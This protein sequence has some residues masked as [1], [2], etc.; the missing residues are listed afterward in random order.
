MVVHDSQKR[1][2]RQAVPKEALR[3]LVDA[4]RT[5]DFGSPRDA[6][7]AFAAVT[8]EICGAEA[9]VVRLAEPDGAGLTAHAVHATSPALAAELAGSRV[10]ADEASAS[11]RLEFAFTAPI[12]LDGEV[13]GSLDVLRDSSPFS[14]GEQLLAQLAAGELGLVLRALRPRP[15]DTES[16][17]ERALVLAGEALAAGSDAEHA[18]E[19]VARLAADAAGA[20]AVVL[21]R[22]DDGKPKLAASFGDSPAAESAALSAARI[23]LDSRN[24]FIKDRIGGAAVVSVRLGEPAVGVLQ[25]V[26][27]QDPDESVLSGLMTFALRA[28]QTLRAG[29]SSREAVR[30]L[31]RTRAL[32]AVVAQATAHLSLQHALAT[33]IE[34]VTVLVGADR[35]AVYLREGKRLQAAASRNLAGPHSAVAER[36]LELA[37]GPYRGR[38]MVIVSELGR[39][40]AFAEV[41]DAASEAG[42]RAA[43]ALPLVVRGEAIGLLAAYPTEG[44]HVS[45]ED[46]ALLAA[47]AAQLA[48]A[49]QNARLHEQTKTLA[50]DLDSSLD[51][52]REAA[53]RVR[54]LYEVSES[55]AQSLSL[56]ATLDALARSA[57]ELLGVDAAV[58]RMPDVRREMLEERAVHVGDPRLGEAAIPA[59]THPQTLD[60]VPI[61]RLFRTRRPLVLNPELARELGGSHRLLAPFLEKGSSVAVVPIATPGEVIGT[62]TLVSFDPGRPI[63]RETL[64]TAL[65]I[66][67]QA[68]LA[69]DNG[70]LYQQQKEFA[71]TMRRSLLPR[72]HP[73]LQGLEIGEV[74]QPSTRVD[75]GGDV[76]DFL[77]LG[78]GRLAVVL[79]DVTG[80]GI[81]ATSDMAMAKFVF[82]SLAREHPGPADFLASANEVVV[83][84]IAAGK[85]ITMIYLTVEPATGAV[86]AASAG[87]PA[88]LL[89]PRKGDVRQLEVR[90]LALGV[91]PGQTYEEQGAR[92][93]RGDAIVVYTDG[94]V[95]AR[96]DGELYGLERLAHVLGGLRERPAAEIASTVIDD[97]RSFAGALADDCAVVV[98]KSRP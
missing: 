56:N 61:R 53:R 10:V 31:E 83:G 55:F 63:V 85:F 95:E 68:A 1:A 24:F 79:G 18:A 27:A 64:D 49:V 60:V 88:P 89:V 26:F 69:I 52:E 37:L 54:A 8:V 20:Q 35:A 57:V 23:A 87:H 25:L 40:D 45:S 33:A 70:R 74:Y 50:A 82:R 47:L 93:E 86:V 4:V 72:S 7:E 94:V 11:S 84:E 65:S 77:E 16:A 91:E 66:A 80:H 30:E 39:D 29:D 2:N 44:P 58:I 34:H 9:A 51:A 15:A 71:D 14:E 28:A 62:L 81:E 48:I 22:A 6:L 67:A 92:L 76:Y 97:C 13:A 21:W 78:D 75:V 38:G 90:G 3:A 5:A 32:L 42:V 41:R 12:E 43:L 17:A 36:L 96:R 59:L 73:E 46:E 19:H 98:I